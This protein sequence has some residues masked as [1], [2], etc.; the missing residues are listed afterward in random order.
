MGSFG[1]NV[2]ATFDNSAGNIDFG[3][4]GQHEKRNEHEP[5]LKPVI[6][7]GARVYDPPSA[8]S[9]KSTRSKAV[10]RTRTHTSS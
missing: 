2:T 5:G 6:E 1:E 10:V 9:S 8:D 7:M 3:W 4:V